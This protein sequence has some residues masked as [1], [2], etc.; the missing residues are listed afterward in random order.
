MGYIPPG[1][2]WYLADIVLEHTIEDEPRNV[3]HINTVLVRANSPERAYAHALQLGQEAEHKYQNTDGKK[4]E[5]KF[6]GLSD[7]NVI[8]D[9]LRSGAELIYQERTGIAEDEV[10]R[11]ISTKEELGVFAERV[12]PTRGKPNYMP[13]SVMDMLKAEGFSE[14]DIYEQEHTP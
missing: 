6:R 8:C 9:K 5:T 13:G 7:L 14:D 1:A 4:V 11:L 3:V 10:T 12:K 2:R